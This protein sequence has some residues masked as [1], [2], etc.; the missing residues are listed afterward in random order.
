MVILPWI[1]NSSLSLLAYLIRFWTCQAFYNHVRWYL[2]INLSLSLSLCIQI[3][4]CVYIYIYIYIYMYVC[5]YVYTYLLIFGSVSLENFGYSTNIAWLIKFL[6]SGEENQVH[7]APLKFAEII[8]TCAQLLSC[9][10][11]F[12]TP[13]TCL[14]GSSVHGTFQVRILEWIA[15]FFSRY[16]CLCYIIPS[17]KIEDIHFTYFF[18]F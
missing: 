3:Y 1:P 18:V 13:Q 10:W 4:M 6:E 16:F 15:I 14:L 2:K 8:S 17:Q 9:V 12:A 11:L 5:M 7:S